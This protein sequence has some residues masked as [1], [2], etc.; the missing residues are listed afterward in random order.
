MT[1]STTQ[2][3]QFLQDAI[4][5]LMEANRLPDAQLVENIVSEYPDFAAEI[6]D[7]AVELA[8]DMLIN[9]DR[10]EEAVVVQDEVS[11]LVSRALSNFENELFLRDSSS[12]AD[13]VTSRVAPE[14]KSLDPFAA[15]DR[16]SFGQFAR[17]IHANKV[18]ALKLR[19]RQIRPDTIPLRYL[20]ITSECLKIRLDQL[21]TYLN[22]SG[23][24]PA[25]GTQ[26][27]KADDRPNHELQQSFDEAVESSGLTG[28][29]IQYLM[30]LK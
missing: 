1:P 7:F 17:S 16:K 18:F 20:E 2:S 21:L 29:Q 19:D 8:I 26:F 30:S 4:F 6:T 15:M 23:H 10:N 12:K 28:D 27:F 22:V 5:D 25:M 14:V 9:S 11:P 24:R 3:E 13:D